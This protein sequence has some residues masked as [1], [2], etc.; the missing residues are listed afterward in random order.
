VI[1]RVEI[2]QRLLH[3]L[4]GGLSAGELSEWAR[5]ALAFA[6]SEGPTLFVPEEAMLLDVLKRCAVAADPPFE[7]SEND[8]LALLRRVAFAG[9]P[10]AAAGSAKGPFLVALRARMAPARFFPIAGVC[11][12]CGSAVRLSAAMLP[13]ARRTGGALICLWCARALPG[14][15][16]EGG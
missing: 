10:A 16:V 3:R 1:E 15:V 4:S 9:G 8:L 14:M 5:S 12:R 13:K 7:L 6:T 11:A 2:E